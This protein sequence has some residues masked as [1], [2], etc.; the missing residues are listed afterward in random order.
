MAHLIS[1]IKK[2]L[3]SA[4]Y[5]I[6]IAA[7]GLLAFGILMTGS[8]STGNSVTSTYKDII[9]DNYDSVGSGLVTMK[10]MVMH[11]I[12]GLA[13]IFFMFLFMLGFKPGALNK[14]K[15]CLAMFIGLA[16]CGVCR[17]FPDTNGSYAWLNFKVFTIQ[18]AEFVKIIL[19]LFLAYFFTK[20][21]NL[22][23]LTQ[24]QVDLYFSRYSNPMMMINKRQKEF[25]LYAYWIPL[26]VVFILLVIIAAVQKDIGTALIM[27]FV[28]CVCIFCAQSAYYGIVQKILT[29]GLSMVAVCIP[30]LYYY[31]TTIPYESV[32]NFRL[33]R[34]MSL[35]QPLA[36]PYGDSAQLANTLVA[37]NKGGLF[38]V[39]LYN[40]KL[41]Y[42]YISESL[43]DFISGIIIEELG[44]IGLGILLVLYGIII[45]R[46]LSYARKTKNTQTS[47][48]LTGIASI[49]FIHLLLNLGGATGLIPMTGVPLIFVSKG[50]SSTLAGF[51]ALGICEAYIMSDKLKQ[52]S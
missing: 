14:N 11:A 42:G 37:I 23:A 32:K 25:N 12:Y 46:L 24:E 33:R 31:A 35:M 21:C 6:I 28:I 15:L 22:Y 51:I 20:L 13:G 5:W 43:T 44:L 17:L 19:V 8:A 38:G 47:I 52:K 1:K 7:I 50:G 4:D 48:V 30:L 2:Q 18:P 29:L 10:T 34:F 41:K 26:F 36:D 45:F 16:L 49:F 39:G 27:F 3:S 40:S 9:K